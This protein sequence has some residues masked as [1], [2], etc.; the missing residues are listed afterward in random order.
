MSCG[1]HA[2]DCMRPTAAPDPAGVELTSER[3]HVRARLAQATGLPADAVRLT[4]PGWRDA[5]D[6]ALGTLTFSER[7]AVT[8]SLLGAGVPAASMPAAQAQERIAAPWLPGLLE[9]PERLFP[10][11]QPIVSLRDG[12]VH[13]YESLLRARIGGRELSGGEI[14]AAAQAHQAMFSLDLIGRSVALEQGL[15]ALPEDA[16]LFVNFTPSAIYDPDIC[17]RTTWA[18]ARRL[19]FPL[20]RVCFEVVET[21]QFPDVPFLLRI[22]DRYRAEGAQVAL[23]DLGAGHSSLSY[24]R[25]L[26]PDVVKLDR[27]LVSGIDGDN[28]RQRLLSALL[29]YAHELDIKVVAEG[30]ETEAELATVRDLGA[31]LGQ[32]WYLGRPAAAPQP[33]DPGLVRAASAGRTG[34]GRSAAG[35]TL[36]DRALAAATSG[37]VIT[38]ARRPDHPV[39]YVNPAFERMTGYAQAEVLGRNC[40]FLQG[41]DTDP[42]TV[43]VLGDA[44]R[45]HTEVRATLVNHRRDGS[46]FWCELNLAPVLD[47]HGEVIQYVGVQNDVTARVEAEQHLRHLAEHDALTGLPNRAALQRRAQ[48]LLRAHA[49]VALLFVD[50]DGFKNVNDALGHEAGDVALCRVAER[51][52]EA[53]GPGAFVARHAGDEFVVLLEGADRAAA[54]LARAEVEAALRRPVDVQGGPVA[55]PASVGVAAFPQDGND[56]A[57]LLRAADAGMY[58]RKALRRV[59]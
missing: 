19:G 59:A 32:G 34:A 29:D 51:L 36:R 1:T 22:L 39:V 7:A 25:L 46:P 28:A 2:C 11:F 27:Q 33:V 48:E 4:G 47:D 55:V 21:E 52:R 45:A 17:L 16:M 57:G 40:R 58:E 49:D 3:P 5:F 37:V 20:S 24:L 56:V 9:S 10:H 43:R 15:P 8:A 31:D 6:A 44:L 35:L 50:L 26:R 53:A 12:S 23:D 30:I 41:P 13:G 14:V 54:H 42:A 38:D 18:I